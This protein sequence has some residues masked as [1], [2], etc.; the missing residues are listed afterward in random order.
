MTTKL[1]TSGQQNQIA[2]LFGVAGSTA[3]MGWLAEIA[4]TITSEEAQKVI[5]TGGNFQVQI[6][7]EF[8]KFFIQAFWVASGKKHTASAELEQFFKEVFDYHVDLTGVPFPEKEGMPAYMV[9]GLPLTTAVIMERTTLHFKVNPY[10]WKTLEEGSMIRDMSQ[11]RPQGVYVFAH[12]GDDEPDAKHRNKSFDDFT[13]EKLQCMDPSEY[14]LST[15]FHMWKHKKWMDVKG[16]TR[17]SSLWSLGLAVCG[18]FYSDRRRL[19]LDDDDRAYRAAVAGPRE[20][21]LG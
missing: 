9:G 21:F 5:T 11:K 1:I 4:G 10:L 17:L 16:W 19:G 2:Q 20:L 6:T 7:P 8:K 13:S 18:C 3:A 15:A 14:L 12:T